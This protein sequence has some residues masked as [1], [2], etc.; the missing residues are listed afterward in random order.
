MLC[1]LLLLTLIAIGC[2]RPYK[3]EAEA[4]TGGSVVRGKDAIAFY[5]CAS[6]HNIP[7]IRGPDAQVGPS[8][9]HVG[10][11][12]YIGVGLV[13]TPDNMIEWVKH[14]KDID[15]KAAM[16]NLHIA[17]SDVRDIVAY[18]RTLR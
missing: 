4:Q 13:N 2:D 10:S 1:S 6:C 12:M 17:E 5:G 15:P 14:P 8:L 11:R 16:P 3:A 18:L 9:E 7:G